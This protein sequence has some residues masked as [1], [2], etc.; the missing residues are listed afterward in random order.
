MGYAKRSKGKGS[1]DDPRG[2]GHHLREKKQS[3]GGSH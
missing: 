1:T 3:G 2:R